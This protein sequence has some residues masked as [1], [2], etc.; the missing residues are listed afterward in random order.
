MASKLE[1]YFVVI[2]RN[3]ATVVVFSLAVILC[4]SVPLHAQTAHGTPPSVT[5]LGFGGT[6]NRPHGI[7]PSV[8][9]AGFGHFGAAPPIQGH[10]RHNPGQGYPGVY[11]F[12]YAY[13]YVVDG[14]PL[15][16]SQ[17][18]DQIAGPAASDRRAPAPAATSDNLGP[19]SNP[20]EQA[21]AAPLVAEADTTPQPST[22]LVFKDGHQ[23]EIDNYAIVGAT[24][25]DLSQDRRWKIGLSELDLPATIKAN[26]DRGLDFQLPASA[27]AN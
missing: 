9:S 25:Y 12:P 17:D 1:Y 18:E 4:A 15:D 19:E 26:N 5:S 3:A 2:H 7:S 8:T 24:L 16:E 13:P 6:G 22:V 14:P 10:H 27:Q 21:Q 23:V 20:A 11:Y